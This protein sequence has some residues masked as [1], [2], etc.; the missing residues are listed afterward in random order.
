MESARFWGK[1][2]MWVHLFVLCVWLYAFR[3][4]RDG[5]GEMPQWVFHLF[6]GSIVGIQFTWGYT[7]GLMVGPSRR[8]RH[9]LWWS[10]ITLVIPMY[11][12]GGLLRFFFEFM[13]VWQTGYYLLLFAAVLACETYGGVLLGAKA[14][15]GDW[16]E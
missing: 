10:L 11:I 7:V 13:G 9:K 2:L 12:V 8:K 3:A 15:A 6:I 14:H 5:S 4:F 1:V 16:K